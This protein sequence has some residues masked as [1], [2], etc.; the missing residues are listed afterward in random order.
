MFHAMGVI[1]VRR[2]NVGT[3]FGDSGELEVADIWLAD[4]DTWDIDLAEVVKVNGLAVP[5]DRKLTYRVMQHELRL[6][7]SFLV[8]EPGSPLTLR[9]ADFQASSGHV[10]RFISESFGLGMLTAAAERH[11]RW[12]LNDSDLHNFDVLP[13]KVAAQYPGSGIR[14]DLLFDFT[15]Q[16]QEKRLAGEARGRSSARPV[17]PASKDQRDRLDDVVVWSGVN[18]LHPVTMTYAYTGAA[19]AQVDLFDIT[20]PDHLDVDPEILIADEEGLVTTRTGRRVERL[21]SIRARAVGR[22][23]EVTDQ[24][25]TTAPAP[26]GAQGR[27]RSVYGRSVRGSWAT[28]DLIAPSGLR[29]F[30]GLLDQPLTPEQAGAPRRRRNAAMQPDADPIQVA[31]TGRI[32]VVVAR[33]T[34]Q[35]PDWSEVTSRIE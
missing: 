2:F 34:T 14:P 26:Q 21:A 3:H 33:D 9:H 11:H 17:H 10:K 29:F 23:G 31:A 32:L 12:E 6:L 20:V 28:A 1:D 24:L 22:A 35:D 5:A 27:T 7:L 25:Y 30:F 19:S 13:A 8:D 16:G 4:E 18:N 15:D